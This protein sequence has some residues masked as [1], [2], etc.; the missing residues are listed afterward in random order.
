VFAGYSEV[1]YN[2]QPKHKEITYNKNRLRV[3][4]NI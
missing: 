1:R 2:N 3:S 4:V